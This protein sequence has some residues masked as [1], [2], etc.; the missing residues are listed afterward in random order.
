MR[1]SSP[2]TQLQLNNNNNNSETNEMQFL[3]NLLRI[4]GPYMFG[5]SLAHPQE[6]L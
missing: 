3:F 4:K 6:A 1:V 2:V 5:A